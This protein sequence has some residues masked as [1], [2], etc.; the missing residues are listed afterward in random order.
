[1]CALKVGREGVASSVAEPRLFQDWGGGEGGC[2]IPFLTTVFV[3]CILPGILRCIFFC[4]KGN[5]LSFSFPAP[6]LPKVDTILCL[7]QREG[8]QVCNAHRQLIVCPNV[9]HLH[10]YNVNGAGVSTVPFIPAFPQGGNCLNGQVRHLFDCSLV[11][12]LEQRDKGGQ[13]VMQ[14]H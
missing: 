12:F 3:I 9:F 5:A 2:V 11:V 6:W 4:V 7:S 10:V 14:K 1:M 8:V 13:S